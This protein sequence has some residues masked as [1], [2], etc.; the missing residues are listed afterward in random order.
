MVDFLAVLPDLCDEIADKANDR[1][2]CG[3]WEMVLVM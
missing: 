1:G 2:W 3:C